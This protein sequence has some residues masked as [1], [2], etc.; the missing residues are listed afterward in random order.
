VTSTA[1]TGANGLDTGT[2]AAST[3]YYWYAI[4]NANSATAAGLLSLSSTAP[5]LPSGYTYS[6]RLGAV[7]TDGSSNLLRT[8]QIGSKAQYVVG[9]NP[10]QTVVIATATAGTYSTTSPVLVTAM[11]TGIVPATA[12]TI[13]VIGAGQYKGGGPSGVLLAPNI[14]WGGVNNGPAGTN[15]NAFPLHLPSAN[16]TIAAVIVLETSSVAWAG[17]GAGAAILCQGWEDNIVN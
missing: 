13:T 17:G 4:Y 11:V 2:V 3:W 7:R 15:G 10:V 6:A 14:N 16:T 8:L 12:Q 1:T 5:A 9:T